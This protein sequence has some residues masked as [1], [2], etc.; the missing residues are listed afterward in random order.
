MQVR[1]EDLALSVENFSIIM[2]NCWYFLTCSSMIQHES[3]DKALRKA[4]KEERIIIFKIIVTLMSI[5]YVVLCS[6]LKS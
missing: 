2:F 4:W 1:S 5:L 3:I 6:I